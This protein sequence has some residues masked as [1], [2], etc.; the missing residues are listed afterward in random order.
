MDNV[1]TV[2]F[3]IQEVKDLKI[4]WT[5]ILLFPKLQLKATKLESSTGSE[6]SGFQSDCCV[7]NE[8]LQSSTS[9][10]KPSFFLGNLKFIKNKLLSLEE[11]KQKC[12]IQN[13]YL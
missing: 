3:F 5:K 6:M 4:L 7:P 13:S 8:L 12:I 1:W 10:N 11:I 2:L 9:L